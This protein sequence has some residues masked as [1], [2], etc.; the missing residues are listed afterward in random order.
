MADANLYT[1]AEVL[2]CQNVCLSEVELA[3]LATALFG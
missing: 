3:G 1:I 2:S